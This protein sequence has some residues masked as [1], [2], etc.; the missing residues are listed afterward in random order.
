MSSGCGSLDK[1]ID[2]NS[3]RLRFESNHRQNSIMAKFTVNY[4]KTKMKLEIAQI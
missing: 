2:S 4:L 1:V 3:G